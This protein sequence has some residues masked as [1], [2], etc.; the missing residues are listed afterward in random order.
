MRETTQLVCG[1]ISIEVYVA[2]VYGDQIYVETE[3]VKFQAS[4]GDDGK[5]RFGGLTIV[6]PSLLTIERAI[7]AWSLPCPVNR[8]TI[9]D[10]PLP[11]ARAIQ[12][13]LDG[14]EWASL[15]EAEAPKQGPTPNS[16]SSTGDSPQPLV[17]LTL[18]S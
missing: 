16:H 6:S 2:P 12:R 15:G 17:A 7:K 4:M 5:P 13:Y 1:D 14:S 18:T 11:V 10:L 3:R 9:C 8:V